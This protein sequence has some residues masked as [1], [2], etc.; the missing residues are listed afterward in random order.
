MERFIF[1]IS[2]FLFSIEASTCDLPE[3]E[4]IKVGCSYECNF[5]YRFRINL[6]ALQMGYPVEFVNLNDH[7]NIKEALKEVDG[8]LLPGGA[9]IDPRY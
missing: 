9:D 7:K 3:G 4:K 1:F 6:T 8:I 5:F 2:L